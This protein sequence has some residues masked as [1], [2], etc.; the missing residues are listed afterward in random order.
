M[1]A[2]GREPDRK[3][4]NGMI[5]TIDCQTYMEHTPPHNTIGSMGWPCYRGAA[6]L[7]LPL[8]SRAGQVLHGMV[9]YRPES[10]RDY[11][12]L[13]IQRRRPQY[14][15]AVDYCLKQE[16][17]EEVMNVSS[18]AVCVRDNYPAQRQSKKKAQYALLR[19]NVAFTNFKHNGLDRDAAL[20]SPNG[21]VWIN[22]TPHEPEKGSLVVPVSLCH[23]ALFS[24][25]EWKAY[26]HLG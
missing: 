17:A 19:A 13:D 5:S 21:G 10:A 25:R 6:L 8:L 9:F 22:C 18:F 14:K 12:E 7:S 1:T 24:S 23:A 20:A 26:D 15:I 16:K 11:S 3:I 4:K 2:S